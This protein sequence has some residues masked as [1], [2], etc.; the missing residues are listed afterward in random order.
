M[1]AAASAALVALYPNNAQLVTG[2]LTRPLLASQDPDFLIAGTS[3]L[4]GFADVSTVPSL[5]T[6]LASPNSEVKRNVTWAFYRIHSSSNPRVV[7]ELQK[8]ITN[9]NESIEVRVN[10]VRAVG[11]IGYDTAQLNIWQTLV[12]TAQMRGDKYTSLRFYAVRALGGFSPAKPQVLQALARIAAKDADAEL[13]K[14][15]LRSLIQLSADDSTVEAAIA[16]TAR[17][18]G[19]RR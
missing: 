6:L 10:A 12:T 13:R 8:L 2:S 18:E 19:G 3:L 17:L 15:A 7:D 11:A 14:E 1:R 9:E 16:E 5:L 4:A